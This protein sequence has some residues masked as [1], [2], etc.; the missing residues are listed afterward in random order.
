MLRDTANSS[1][2]YFH[3]MNKMLRFSLTSRLAAFDMKHLFVSRLSLGLAYLLTPVNSS[4]KRANPSQVSNF[5]LLHVSLQLT[6]F[7][8]KSAQHIAMAM[9]SVQH[10]NFQSGHETFVC[11]I[12]QQAVR[13]GE[14]IRKIVLCDHSYHRNCLNPWARNSEN[15]TCPLRCCRF[16]RELVESIPE[17]ERRAAAEEVGRMAEDIAFFVTERAA[18]TAE[19]ARRAAG[20]VPRRAAEAARMAAEEE[21]ARN[22]WGR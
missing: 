8:R 21:E 6:P 7:T 22:R 2:G 12:C 14:R 19:I 15:P 16:E 10:Y 11:V 17:N 18:R 20:E 9:A 4:L 3:F 1:S 13:I 5:N